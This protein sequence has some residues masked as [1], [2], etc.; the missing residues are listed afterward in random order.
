MRHKISGNNFGRTSAH[1]KAL[2]RNLARALLTHE[3]IQTTETKAKELRRVTEQ[4]ITL[5]LR[6]DLHA[7]RQA[8]EVLENHKL[9]Q[10]LFDELGPRFVGV[11]GGYTRIVKL[12]MPRKGDCAPMAIIELTLA[13]GETPKP[14][15]E[16][17]A[18]AVP[19]AAPVAAPAAAE[20]AAEAP[21]AEGESTEA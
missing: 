9:V 6:N 15:K 11:N 8:Y 18:A 19:V 17:P 5:A 1:R 13:A 20:T 21:A 16:R 14:P 3:R 7:R 2:F 4:L 10:R 12:A